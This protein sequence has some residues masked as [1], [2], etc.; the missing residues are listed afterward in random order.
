MALI[1]TASL[2]HGTEVFDVGDELTADGAVDGRHVARRSLEQ[3]RC[4]VDD[5]FFVD[6]TG[7]SS[8]TKA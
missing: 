2:K 5:D 1:R 4:L 3:R 6:P 8:T 7:I